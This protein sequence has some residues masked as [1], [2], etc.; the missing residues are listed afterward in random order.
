MLMGVL[1]GCSGHETKG[2]E[3]TEPN[4][5]QKAA[6][7]S[8]QQAEHDPSSKWVKVK[9]PARIPILMYHSIS[10]GNSLRVPE[11]EFRGHMK[12]L[13]DNGYYTLTPEEAYIVLT[14][15]KMP[16]DKCVLITFDDGYTDNFEKAYPILK[17]YGMK[18]TIFMIGKSV[19]GKNHLTEK[20]M[21]EM[22]RNGISIQSH[23][24]H[25]VELNGLA[26]GQ[27]LDEMTRSKAL[28]DRMFSQNTVM[29][30]YPVGRYN[31]DTLKLAKQAGY[32]MAV[33]TEPGAASRD[34]GMYALHRVRI[35]PGMS[36]DA[37]G[38]M[39]EHSRQ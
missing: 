18:A 11:G 39:V 19:G 4:T 7:Q 36:P 9:S 22:R 28:F 25:H 32:Q 23:T 38:K 24:I 13:K 8:K 1:Y 15:D 20:Q 31:E 2:E 26:P 16:S 6:K 14:Q 27:Q 12:W 21:N 10:S 29:L 33:T 17:G 3:K 30:S 37:F 5:A 34:Q 35:S